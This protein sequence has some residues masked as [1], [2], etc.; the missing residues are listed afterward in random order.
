MHRVW[1][2]PHWY[3]YAEVIIMLMPIVVF[4]AC[5]FWKGFRGALLPWLLGNKGE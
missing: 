5:Y 1:H 4:G 2:P 3:Q